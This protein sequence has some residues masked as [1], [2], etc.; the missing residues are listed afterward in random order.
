MLGN[1]RRRS[2]SSDSD[3]TYFRL[4]GGDLF[5]ELAHIGNKLRW[6]I[7]HLAQLFADFITLGSERFHLV[8][9]LATSL[10]KAL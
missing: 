9:K 6:L 4:Q 8:E 7:C 10:I 1:R 3:L 5:P 2:S